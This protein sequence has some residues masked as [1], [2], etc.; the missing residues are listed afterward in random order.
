MTFPPYTYPD[1]SVLIN[2]RNIRDAATL[3]TLE[4]KITLLALSEMTDRVIGDFDVVHLKRIHYVLF[5]HLYAWAGQ[6]RLI[7]IGKDQTLFCRAAFLD[8]EAERIAQWI[9]QRHYLQAVHA[10]PFAQQAGE[11]M[12]HLNMLHPF[13]E[14]NGRAQR[15]FVRQLARF[16]GFTLDYRRMDVERYMAASTADDPREMTA[17]LRPTIVNPIPDQILRGQYQKSAEP[18]EER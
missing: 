18:D 1:S 3:E 16:Q 17:A 9:R 12:T 14:G 13:R 7:D 5:H 4:R 8:G 15:E 10:E 2:Q 11:L 6:F